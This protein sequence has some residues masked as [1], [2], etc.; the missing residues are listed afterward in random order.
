MFTPCHFFLGD[1]E[2]EKWREIRK[3]QRDR[4]NQGRESRRGGG[5]R[6]RGRG[7]RRGGGRSN[8]NDERKRV[9]EEDTGAGGDQNDGEPPQKALKTEIKAE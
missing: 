6:G 8:R 1:E 4:K 3:A 5:G 2:I 7:G 9:K